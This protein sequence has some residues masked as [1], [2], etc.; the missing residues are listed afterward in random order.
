MLTQVEGRITALTDRSHWYA[1]GGYDGIA[2]KLIGTLEVDR[3]LLE[4]DD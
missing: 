2:E 4:Y 1:E 3:F